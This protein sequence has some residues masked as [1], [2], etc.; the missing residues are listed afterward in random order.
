MSVKQQDNFLIRAAKPINA[1]YFRPGGT[2]Y[3]SKADVM[4]NCPFPHEYLIVNIN[5]VEWQF[6]GGVQESNL[7]IYANS[8]EQISVEDN[9]ESTSSDNALSANMGR[10]LNEKIT[11]KITI[12]DYQFT[13]H[14]LNSNETGAPVEGEM[15]ANGYW[16]DTT[17]VKYAVYNTGDPTLRS[18]YT[19]MEWLGDDPQ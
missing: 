19:P 10:V 17:F 16:G 14:K 3:M 4:A 7:S 5:G 9:L 18:S 2:P 15:V 6:V 11:P 8:Q 13:W 12:E 1:K